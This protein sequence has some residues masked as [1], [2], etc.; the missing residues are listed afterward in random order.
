MKSLF[1]VFITFYFVSFSFSQ[2]K[3]FSLDDIVEPN[4]NEKLIAEHI[5]YVNDI[6]QLAADLFWKDFGKD[7]F[8]GTIVYFTDSL[9]YFFNP[10]ESV[11]EKISK[12]KSIKIKYDW[13]MLRLAL[14]FDEPTF[15]I[16]TIFET[17]EGN[18]KNI[19]YMLP[20][21]FCSSPE[22]SKKIQPEIESTE[23]WGVSV[24]HENYHQ[25]QFKTKAIYSYL[26]TFISNNTMLNKDSVQSIYLRFPNFKDT[27]LK[28][29]DLLLK[30]INSSSIEQEK[31]YFEQFLK[32][33]NKR[34]LEFQKSQKIK[35]AQLEDIWEK[36]EGTTLYAEAIVKQNFDKLP[37]S[38]YL[39]ANDPLFLNQNIFSNFSMNN[40]PKYTTIEAAENY[41]GV[42]GYNLVRLLEKHNVD[43]KSDFYTYASMSL[44]TKLKYFYKLK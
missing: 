38:H 34:R 22:V 43:Y 30:A 42:T 15:V 16:Q 28:E 13:V 14:P 20:I 33:R 21:L 27:L 24:L 2:T 17:S 37:K 41:F 44:A 23:K 25:Y 18:K 32:L 26:N 3:V 40:D 9:S 39:I 35:I 5:K 31:I 29:N 19:N 1:F 36:L 10:E 4:E 12:Y 11:L 7:E 6:R 8:V